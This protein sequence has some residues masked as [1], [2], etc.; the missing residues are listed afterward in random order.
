MVKLLREDSKT[1]QEIKK[2][3]ARTAEPSARN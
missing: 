1:L 2:T 3:P